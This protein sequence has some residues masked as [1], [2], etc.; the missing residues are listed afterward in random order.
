MRSSFPV[1][2]AV[3]PSAPLAHPASLRDHAANNQHD[4]R[5]QPRNGVEVLIAAVRHR[6][7]PARGARS[8]SLDE[9]DVERQ[10]SCAGQQTER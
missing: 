1:R 2:T 6:R 8:I 4:A 5:Y 7:M 10:E 9:R 3:R